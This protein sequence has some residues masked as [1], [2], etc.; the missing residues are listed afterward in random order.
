MPFMENIER[1]AALADQI[2]AELDARPTHPRLMAIAGIP[3]SGKTTIAAEL[4]ARVPGSVVVP[5]DG[6]HLPR[7]ALTPDGLIRRGAPDTFDST[8]LR[9]AMRR[10]REEGRGSFPAFD[11]AVKDP[12]PDKIIVPH[13][14]SLVIVEGIYLL[15]NDWRLTELFDFTVFVDCDLETAADR[16]A[17]RHLACGISRTPEEA[18]DRAITNDRVN[19]V[20]IIND[21]GRERAHLVVWNGT[22]R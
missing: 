22:S 17:A 7:S 11:H 21:G 14:A 13:D 12:E 15:L 18:M 1:P 5:M 9:S 8:A 2:L 4:S 16:V 10:L 20:F 19:S 6:Y 3:G